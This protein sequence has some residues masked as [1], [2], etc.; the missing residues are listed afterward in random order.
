MPNVQEYNYLFVVKVIGNANSG[1]TSLMTRFVNNTYTQTWGTTNCDFLIKTLLIGQKKVKLQIWDNPNAKSQYSPPRGYIVVYDCTDQTSFNA[2]KKHL[3][4][5]RL[6][7]KNEPIVLVGTKSDLICKKV[8]DR[9]TAAKFATDEGLGFVEVSAKDDV[10]VNEV[11]ETLSS[12]M[13]AKLPP[14]QKF[15]NE[16]A[17][18]DENVGTVFE[19]FTSWLRKSFGYIFGYPKDNNTQ[20]SNKAPNNTAVSNNS[21]EDERLS[22]KLNKYVKTRENEFFNSG[23][24]YHWG[25]T[26]FSSFQNKNISANSKIQTANKVITLLDP[27][28]SSLEKT[29]NTFTMDEIATLSNGRLGDIMKE[30]LKNRTRDTDDTN[31]TIY[32]I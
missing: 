11:F 21:N 18:T 17:K 29:Q 14:T 20:S 6:K 3:E 7:S 24:Q 16:S 26:I 2:V 1:K 22:A 4:D 25:A 27:Y 19:I 10:N 28:K 8:I 15:D 32:K 30:K 31:N 5:I 9:E 12:Q 23:S 13:I